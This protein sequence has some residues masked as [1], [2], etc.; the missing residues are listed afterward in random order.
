[1]TQGTRIKE[2]LYV[3]PCDRDQSV[4]DG[5]TL[6]WLVDLTKYWALIGGWQW[7]GLWPVI[8]SLPHSSSAS[9]QTQ[10]AHKLTPICGTISHGNI[11]FVFPLTYFLLVERPIILSRSVR[12]L[13]SSNTVLKF[14]NTQLLGYSV[15]GL[16]FLMKKS[17][18]M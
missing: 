17:F 1:M 18:Y 10:S 14:S 7:W 11:F 6:S 13:L 12:M 16:I 15:V 9:H 3:V 2:Y 4:Q 5:D 8:P